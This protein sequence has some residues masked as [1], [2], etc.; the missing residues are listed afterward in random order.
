MYH[1]HRR[2]ATDSI[3][4]GRADMNE[5]KRLRV[6]M[7]GCGGLARGVLLPA[8]SLVDELR[9]VATCDLRRDAAEDAADRFRAERA[10]TDY[11]ELLAV[12]EL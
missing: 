9:L 2:T 3:R 5:R 12:E 1:P 4:I 8:L 11:S 6:A 7:I 10:Y